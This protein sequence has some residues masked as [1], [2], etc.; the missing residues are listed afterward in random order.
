M[1]AQFA[2]GRARALSVIAV[3][4]LLFSSLPARTQSTASQLRRP[5][6]DRMAHQQAET[7][8]A[9]RAASDD[10]MRLQKITYRSRT[11]DLEIP[12]FV[13]QPLRS[14]GPR[15]HPAL[16]WVHEDIRGHL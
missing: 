14:R 13:F 15:S 7:D 16:V 1:P 4:C 6:F 8:K 9:W 12:A 5:D 2:R 11:G 3:L 10:R